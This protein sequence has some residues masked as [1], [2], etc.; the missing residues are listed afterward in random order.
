MK[1]VALQWLVRLL[2]WLPVRAV[3]WSDDRGVRDA[4]DL[5]TLAVVGRTHAR[6]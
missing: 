4:A 6:R 1:R 2:A 3:D 5:C